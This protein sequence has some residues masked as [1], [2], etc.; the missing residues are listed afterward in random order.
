DSDALIDFIYPGISEPIPPPNYFLKCMILAAHN[1]NV[2]GLND[3]ILNHMSD[4]QQ[5]FISADK[6]M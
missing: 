3:T 4:K 6:I 1:G 5:T 2:D